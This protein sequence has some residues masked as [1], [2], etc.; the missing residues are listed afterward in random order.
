MLFHHYE[1][2]VIGDKLLSNQTKVRKIITIV[3]Y[4]P[5]KEGRN[6]KNREYSFSVVKRFEVWNKRGFAWND[7]EIEFSIT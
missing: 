7:Y 4:I 5:Y 2:A 3:K 1:T 6:V